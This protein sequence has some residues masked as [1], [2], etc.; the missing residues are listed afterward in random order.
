MSTLPTFIRQS[1]CKSCMQFF[2]FKKKENFGGVH[3][4]IFC[5]INDTR[6][7][8]IL[9]PTAVQLCPVYGTE[10]RNG[11]VMST[12]EVGFTSNYGDN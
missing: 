12:F 5:E 3:R 6:S 8:L 11:K 9:L 4:N 7:Q 10:P 1:V 2:F